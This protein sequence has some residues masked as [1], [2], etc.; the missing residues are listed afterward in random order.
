MK[1]FKNIISSLFFKLL[2]VVLLVFFTHI[3]YTQENDDLYF[4]KNDRKIVVHKKSLSV[5]FVSSYTK[6]LRKLVC[7][8]TSTIKKIKVFIN[9]WS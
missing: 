5:Y 7:S 6:P 3:S 8:Y 1:S 4:N 9:P 2:P